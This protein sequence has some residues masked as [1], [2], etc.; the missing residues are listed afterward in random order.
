MN[1][2]PALSLAGVWIPVDTSNLV[3]DK[4]TGGLAQTTYGHLAFAGGAGMIVSGWG[5]TGGFG[6]QAALSSP[7]K[8]R[9]AVLAP[10]GDG[11][12]KLATSQYLASDVTSGANSVA[13]ADFNGDGRADFF[14]PAHNESPFHAEPSTLYLANAQGTF[15]RTQLN[16]SVMAHDAQFA[17]VNNTPT[18]FTATFTPG[19][20]NP[21]YTFQNG[22]LQKTI[23]ANLSTIFY[24]SI[25]WGNFGI[26]GEQ[27]VAMGDV[28]SNTPGD[29]AKIKI[30]SFANGDVT[31]TTPL[32]TITPYLSLKYPNAT[33]IY[34]TGVTHSYRLF[35][36]DFNHDGK[37]DLLAEES[38]WNTAHDYPTVLQMIQNQG[39]GK[40][41][42]KTD[43]LASVVNQNSQELDYQPQ[44]IDLDHSGINSYLMAG[45]APGHFA[46]GTMR[47]DTARAPNYLLL[48]DG[49]GRLYA[50]LHNEFADLGNQVVQYLKPLQI[51]ADGSRNFYLGNGTADDIQ[52]AGMPKFV[53]H[54]L[55]DG[56]L[57]YVAELQ[58]GYWASPGQWATKY[59]FVNVPLHYN[60]TTDFTQNVT[61]QD[62]NGSMLMRSWAG[63]DI[64]YD[65]NAALSARI[66]GGLG[67]DTAVYSGKIASYQVARGISNTVSVTSNA[68]TTVPGVADT[69]TSI[70]RL[71]FADKSVNLTVGE[72][73]KS[74]STAA[75]DS[76]VELYIA[77]INRVPDADGMAYWIGKLKEGQSLAQIGDSFYSAA[78]QYADLTDYAPNMSD[79]AFV[80]V[81]YKNVLGRSSVDADGL[82]YWTGALATGA[83]THASLVST[84]LSSAHTFKGDAG[85][86]Y[87]ADLLDNRIAVGKTFAISSGL[88]YNTPDESIVQGMAI[89]AA[90]TPT[91]TSEAIRLIGVQDIL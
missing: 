33:S 14:L 59:V 21:I 58:V 36:D 31:S 86:G 63:A 30:Y 49:T 43:Q 38:M 17:V 39:D 60:V 61:V 18:V 54:Q 70:E 84:I 57:N 1:T 3:P 52:S 11:T 13:V 74:V 23:P 44:V 78:I 65:T 55:G 80:K 88:V 7:E 91:D 4:N 22:A 28:Y 19:D 8:V 41:V 9:I 81:I 82:K 66:D 10:Q 12:L 20:H 5:W 29:N 15:D 62:R 72:L 40:F 50:A 73:A 71:Q 25:I 24:Q 27:A 32:A 68:D 85:Y 48:N 45:L 51:N 76:L 77:Y 37:V 6:D 90:I 2:K 83:E 75:L 79:E 47:Y 56:T 46:D 35:T 26:N 53:A 64:F 69:L 34:G 89:A 67:T 16:D 42:D 87:V